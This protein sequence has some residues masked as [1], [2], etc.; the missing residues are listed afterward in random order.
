[1]ATTTA[2]SKLTQPAMTDTVQ[3]LVDGIVSSMNIIDRFYPVGSLYFSTAST[4]PSTF[5]GGTWERITDRMPIGAGTSFPAGQV[6][7]EKE[8]K[9]TT[10]EMPSHNHGLSGVNNG[11]KTTPLAGDYP[12]DIHQDTMP[13]WPLSAQFMGNTGGSSAHNNMPP[14][15]SCY[16]WKRT[17]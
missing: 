16:I 6:G 17:A 11:A 5:I 10:A 15:F 1:M 12:I 9:L 2:T 4:N 3:Q 13:N 14:Y 8:H 7:G